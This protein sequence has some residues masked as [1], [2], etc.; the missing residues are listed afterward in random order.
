MLNNTN[1]SANANI[2]GNTNINDDAN[3][4]RITNTTTGTNTNTN[5]NSTICHLATTNMH[6]LIACNEHDKTSSTKHTT[7]TCS[8][9][10]YYYL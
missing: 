5:T 7:N 2:N 9:N 1:A 4:K 6:T 8:Y 10:Y 3:P